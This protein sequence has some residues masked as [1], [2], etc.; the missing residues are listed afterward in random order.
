M[1]ALYLIDSIT[2]DDVVKFIGAFDIMCVIFH[3]LTNKSIWTLYDITNDFLYFLTLIGVI[4]I[5]MPS[6]FIAK[7]TFY[8]EAIYFLSKHCF[9]SWAIT[10]FVVQMI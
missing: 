3:V 10:L 2:N 5:Y 8:M 4:R 9:I 6:Y 1:E 7:T